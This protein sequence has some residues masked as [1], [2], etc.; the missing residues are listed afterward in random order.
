MIPS[1]RRSESSISGV[2]QSLEPP[3]AV[4][5]LR[6]NDIEARGVHDILPVLLE[7]GRRA[8]N[9]AAPLVGCDR[10]Q[11]VQPAGLPVLHL[12]ESQ[13]AVAAHHQVELCTADV[14]IALEHAPAA[15]NVVLGSRLLGFLSSLQRFPPVVGGTHSA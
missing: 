5:T 3:S 8:A 6:H 7:I 4:H 12:D 9:Q 10:L 13:I 1:N 14:Q 15:G 11:R 2:F